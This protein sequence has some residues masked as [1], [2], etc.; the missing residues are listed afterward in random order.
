MPEAA[1]VLI[2]PEEMALTRIALAAEIDGEIAHARLERRLG[3]AHDVVMG[4]HLLG[5]VI[6]EGQDRAAV[7]HQLLGP[8]GDRGQRVAGDQHR[9][10]EIVGGG[11]DIAAGELVL[12]GKGDG[13]DQEIEA[14]PET[15]DLGEDRIHRRRVGDV[16]MAD[17]MGADLLGQRLD[18]LLQGVALVGQRDIR[19]GIAAGPGDSPG[20]RPVVGD[21][22][23]QAAL[24]LHECA[25]VG[26]WRS[27]CLGIRKAASIAQGSSGHQGR[28]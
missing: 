25:G 15:L 27:C 2:G 21:A 7:G 19:A 20:D 18:A 23:D 14:A 9:L 12:V 8:L 24:P 5:A 28:P 26:H 4:H 10:G 1:S 22:H 6:G 13:M 16:A 17:D 11:V 3:D